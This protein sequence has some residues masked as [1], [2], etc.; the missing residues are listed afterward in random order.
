V[1][2][3]ASISTLAKTRNRGSQDCERNP[4]RGA[5][6]RQLRRDRQFLERL[7]QFADLHG[8]GH[9]GAHGDQS[10]GGSA[11]EDEA[12]IHDG[13]RNRRH[14]VQDVGELLRQGTQ[15]TLRALPCLDKA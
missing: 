10:H 5:H 12:N 8:H 4:Q 2:A 6:L 14:S 9:E 15:R 3:A 7:R 1:C 11:S 13:L